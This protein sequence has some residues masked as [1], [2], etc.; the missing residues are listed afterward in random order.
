MPDYNYWLN[1]TPDDVRLQLVEIKHPSFQRVY[2][3]VQNHADGVRVKL[4]DG[5][6]YD[7][8]YVPLSIQKGTNSDD[9]DQEITVAVGD[10][11][12]I[13]PKEIQRLRN[14]AQYAQTEPVLNYY[15]YNLSDL[16]QPQVSVTGLKVTDYEPK[17]EGGVFTCKARQ[18][19][20]TKTGET[21]N[22]DDYPT[23]RGFI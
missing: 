5:N 13:F 23:L 15:E 6:W 10:L 16:T 11:G 20:V 19:N 9:L 4:P 2:R 17:R 1:G 21:Y 14:S 7:F 22:L 8:E 18:M 3:I 12:E